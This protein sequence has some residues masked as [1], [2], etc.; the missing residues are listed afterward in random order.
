MDFEKVKENTFEDAYRG[1][2]DQVMKAVDEHMRLLKEVD[3]VSIK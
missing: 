2:I 1:N 3:V